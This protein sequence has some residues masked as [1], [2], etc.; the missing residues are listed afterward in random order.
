[1]KKMLLLS[2]MIVTFGLQAQTLEEL[3][4]QKADLLSQQKAKQAEAEAFDTKIG[5]LNKQIEILSGWQTGLSGLVGLNFGSSNNWQANANPNSS[6][7]TLNIGIN[8]FANNIKEKT[9]WRNTLTTNV[10]WQGLDNDTSDGNEGTDFLE[11]RNVDL[12]IFSS[13]Y[14]FRLSEDIAIT[15][16]GDLNTS[17]FN[18]LS[19]GTADIGVG[20]TWTPKAIPNLV[21]VVHPLTYHFAFSSFDNIDSQSALGAK[22]K[23]TYSHEFPGGIVW[24][25][26]FGAF[27]PYN[28]EKFLSF[29]SPIGEEEDIMEGLFEYTWINSLNI[30][31]V[32]KGIGVGLTYGIRDAKFEFSEGTQSYTAIGFTYGF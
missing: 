8:A 22:L 5:D 3:K 12:L 19:P 10:G 9:Y 21:V 28:N 18:F 7:S 16:L 11:S 2:L 15:A 30:A 6:S 17:V 4:T 29:R 24:S 26:N 32:W 13:L 27:L 25:S 31:D 14:G 20:A 23:A 1:M